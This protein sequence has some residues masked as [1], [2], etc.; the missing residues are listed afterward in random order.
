MKV[1]VLVI[2]L[3][4]NTAGWSQNTIGL[5]RMINYTQKELMGGNQTWDIR[6]DSSGRM[7]FAN[8]EGLLSF[9]GNYWKVFPLPNKTILRS[10]YPDERGRIYA[11][12]QG[13][14]GYFEPDAGGILRYHSLLADL[15]A[16]QRVFADIWD[17]EVLGPAVFFRAFDR[18]MEW[19]NGQMQV[20]PARS[21]WVCLKRIGDRLLAQDVMNGL[22][23]W[24]QSQQQWQ[25]LKGTRQLIGKTINGTVAVGR[26]SVLLFTLR[27]GAFI[28][29][30]D[31]LQSYAAIPPGFF[32]SDVNAATGLNENEFAVGTGS[33]GC[34]VL[35]KE[36]QIIQQIARKEGLQNNN[37]ISVFL[38]RDRNLWTGLISGISFIAYNSAIKHIHP[39]IDNELAGFGARILGNRLYLASSD[40][41]YQVEL[42]AEPEDLSFSR[43]RFSLI[44]NS[45]GQVWRIDEVNQQ[46]LMA[47]NNGSFLLGKDKATLLSPLPA[48]LFVPLS[49]VQPAENI[50]VGNYTG[51]RKMR[52][53]DGKFTD[54]G[55]L[56]GLYESLRFLTIDHE[57]RIWASH[58]YRG[59]Y[60]ITL[61][62]DGSAYSAKLY[63]EKDGLPSALG[64]HVFKVRNRVIFAT[65]KGAYEFDATK[66]KFLPSPFLQPA[67]GNIELRYLQED[68]VGN[69]WF[70]SGKKMGIVE[71]GGPNGSQAAITYFPELSGHILSGFEQVYPYN[72]NNVFIASEKGLIHMNPEKYRKNRLPLT[73]ILGGIRAMGQKDSV[74]FGGYGPAVAAKLPSAFRDFH[75]EFSSP[76]YG[77]AGIVEYSY[78]LEGFDKNWSAWSIKT[79]KDYTNL[80]QGKYEFRVKAR[81]NLGQES[82]PVLYSFYIMPPWYL[83]MYAYLLYLALAGFGIYLL[84]RWQQRKLQHQRLQFE[85]KQRQLE[86]L[87][88]L[89][90][91][92]NEKAIIQLQNEKLA[93]EVKYKNRELAD[94]SL[95]LVERTDALAKVKEELQRLYR[96]SDGN[97][98]LK[99]ALQMVSEMERNNE[100]WDRFAARFDEINNDFLK[101]LKERYPVLTGND[102]KLCAYLQLNM[103]SKE[104]AQL[105][106]I[107]LRGVEIGR[108]RLRK[109]LQ[110]PTEK[111]ITEFLHEVSARG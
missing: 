86:V 94:T 85:E 35:N 13:E 75:F 20:Y 105:L 22:L 17:I 41:A 2:L 60:Q 103:S 68:G 10:I 89:E 48:W 97:A 11:G 30:G 106:N 102:L 110:L 72:A 53:Q 14:I 45:L 16:N 18:I 111:S 52:Y 66:Q 100:D 50:L 77:M 87:H 3:L 95:H 8:N 81:N 25:P 65:E 29:R 38:D 78:Q 54:G 5:P 96:S 67:L 84:L 26:D 107:S 24:K 6:Q 44:Q 91:E 33:H 36:G 43:G 70:V 42:E 15:P 83:S 80:T 28:L 12:G 21:E 99:K 101:N 34:Y 104:I 93:D 73:V 49:P 37:I 92:Q 51:L 46:L 76:A 23:E 7:F 19:N 61:A 27:D 64:N 47:H 69:I 62:P 57:N 109:K 40:G 88:Q 63:T 74:L 59:I 108:Y 98:G 31:S 1:G 55:N 71:W 39:N 58:P 79:E 32:P 9:D 82:D 4:W 56:T 90:I